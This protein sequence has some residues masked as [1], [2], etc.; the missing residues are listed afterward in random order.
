[1]VRLRRTLRTPHSRPATIPSLL[2]PCSITSRSRRFARP[3]RKRIGRRL[4]IPARGRK[5]P[6]PPRRSTCSRRS[7]RAHCPPCSLCRPAGSRARRADARSKVFS[8]G[9]RRIR[10]WKRPACRSPHAARRPLLPAAARIQ[11]LA[12]S[13]SAPDPFW[14]PQPSMAPSMR[15][16]P[17]PR[18]WP[19]RPRQT[20][21][22]REVS[23]TGY[24]G[25]LP[26]PHRK[27]DPTN[28]DSSRSLVLKRTRLWRK[29]SRRRRGHASRRPRYTTPQ[30]SAGPRLVG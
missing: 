14:R 22:S 13:W 23:M 30:P 1:M 12:R 26:P 21:G 20:P 17:T 4:R 2:P 3:R 25:R 16:S 15:P 9:R 29:S 24:V 18:P 28:P 10:S 5:R 19:G 27:G 11:L 8:G 7:S 6:C